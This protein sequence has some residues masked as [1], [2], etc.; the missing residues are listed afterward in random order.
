MTPSQEIQQLLCGLVSQDPDICLDQRKLLRMLLE[1]RPRTPNIV[2]IHVCSTFGIAKEIAAQRGF[3]LNEM[4]KERF[5]RRLFESRGLNVQLIHWAIETWSLAYGCSVDEHKPIIEFHEART[6]SKRKT[7]PIRKPLRDPIRLKKHRKE[8]RKMHF[9]PDGKWLA[10]ASFDRTVR[11]WD[12]QKGVQKAVLYG[13]H[14]ERIRGLAYRPD[15]Q[16]LISV[17]DDCGARIWDM[18]TGKKGLR[19][20]GHKA[21][22]I[23]A[24][25]TFSGAHL[26]L[27]GLDKC[28]SIWRVESAEQIFM[29]GPFPDQPSAFCFDPNGKWI[30]VSLPDRV[31]LWDISTQERSASFPGKGVDIQILSCRR[32][33]IIGDERGLRIIDPRSGTHQLQFK[34]H[35]KGISALA[36]DQDEVSL[37]SAGTDQTLRVWEFDSAKL[38]WTFELRRKVTSIDVNFAGTIAVTFGESFGFL[39]PMGRGV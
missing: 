37:I 17:G 21:P 38:C 10:S 30:A 7:L 11:I 27:M 14:R 26:A 25:Y 20:F 28:I 32:G 5:V 2:A 39:F 16:Q 19:L 9:S 33:L 18:R 3:P 6:K 22:V 12:A 34:G 24:L 31:E 8:V 35:Y 1:G 4:R 23:D 29:F 15:G 36:L 13:G